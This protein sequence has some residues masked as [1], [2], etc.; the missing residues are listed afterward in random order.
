MATESSAS[1]SN[2][3]E[4]CGSKPKK[5]AFGIAPLG[6]VA[7][8]IVPMGVVCIGIVPMGVVGI[9]LVSMGAITASVVGMGLLSVGLNTMAVWTAGPLSMG[10]VNLSGSKQQ[11]PHIHHSHPHALKKS[12][13]ES[14]LMYSN[15]KLARLAAQRMGCNTV[16]KVGNYWKPCDENKVSGTH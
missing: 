11:M 13:L 15:E 8:G 5:I 3:S 9:G 12:H 1:N 4:H 7:I 10:F 16:F 6:V 2:T 14:Q